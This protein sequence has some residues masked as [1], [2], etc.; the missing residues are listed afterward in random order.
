MGTHPS[1]PSAITHGPLA[2][3]PLLAYLHDHPDTLGDALAAFGINLP[4]LF[5]VLSVRT[6]LSIQSHPD[7]QLAEHLHATYPHIYKD[8]NHK[9]EMAI[10]LSDF[11]ALCGFCPHEEIVEAFENVPELTACCG[12]QAAEG[13]VLS[14][15]ENRKEALRAAFTALMTADKDAVSAALTTMLQRLSAQQQGEVGDGPLSP[16]PPLTPKELLV[17]R[18]SE[19]YPGDVGILAAWFLNY[20]TLRRGEAIALAANEPHAYLKGEIVECMATSDNVIRAGLTPKLRDTDTLCSSLTYTQG[21]PNVIPAQG[22]GITAQYL[23]VYRPPFKEFE[24]WKFAAPA[25]TAVAMLPQAKGPMIVLVQQGEGEMET[26]GVNG[27]KGGEQGQKR[28]HHV[29]RGQVYFVPAGTWSGVVAETEMLIWM[30][31][32]N[33]MGFHPS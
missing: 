29:H 31:A 28:K 24:V 32:P 18:L 1:G 33:G 25:G 7:K 6:A 14:S 20:I 26:T 16:P 4:F 21:P 10:A 11:E 5:K 13:Y 19:Q 23:S 22:G 2:G 8:N 3:T 9:P 12:R 27:G 30:A 15:I 17:I